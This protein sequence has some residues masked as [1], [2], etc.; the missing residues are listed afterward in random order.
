LK[1]VA[2]ISLNGGVGR[3]TIAAALARVTAERVRSVAIDFDPQN[4]LGLHLGVP[5]GEPR[6]LSDPKFGGPDLVELLRALQPDVPFVPF[7][8][9]TRAQVSELTRT[10]QND[11]RWLSARLE[12][13]LPSG[14]ELLVIDT[15]AGRNPWSDQVADLADAVLVVLGADALSYANLA[16]TENLLEELSATRAG[17]QRAVGFL[18]NRLDPRRPLSRDVRAAFGQALGDRLLSVA[19]YEDESVRE[20]V[21][22]R[23]TAVRYAPH[24]QF[25]AGLHEVSAWLIE[26]LA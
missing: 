7:G 26:A 1:R 15:P 8:R 21:A 11:P 10:V 18:I 5:V 13:L 12:G 14:S 22:E 9:A 25:V 16:D 6:G 20:A 24:S 2:L 23:Q 17:S 3:T 19:L 4:T